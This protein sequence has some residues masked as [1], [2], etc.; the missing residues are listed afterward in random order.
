MSARPF[1]PVPENPFP[2]GVGQ[3]VFALANQPPIRPLP[4]TVVAAKEVVVAPPVP[5]RM[6]ADA[7]WQK[8][9]TANR[10]W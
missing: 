5:L 7:P 2:I 10:T 9:G 8:A 6:P 1:E 4:F 3:S